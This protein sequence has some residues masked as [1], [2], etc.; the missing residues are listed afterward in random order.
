[1]LN[2]VI[3]L[4]ILQIAEVVQLNLLDLCSVG[5]FQSIVSLAI[6]CHG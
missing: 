6:D 1:M 4:E 2:V 3:D 5:L